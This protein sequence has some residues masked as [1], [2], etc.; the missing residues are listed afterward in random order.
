MPDE[1]QHKE[2]AAKPLSSKGQA[3]KTIKSSGKSLTLSK[4]ISAS[5]SVSSSSKDSVKKGKK[6]ICNKIIQLWCIGNYS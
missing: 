4:K 1:A 5:S 3:I 6:G 2:E